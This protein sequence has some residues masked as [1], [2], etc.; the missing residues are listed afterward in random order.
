MPRACQEVS[1][2]RIVV[3]VVVC[4]LFGWQ[5]AFVE[6]NLL[7][8][9]GFE[10]GEAFAE[11]WAIEMWAEDEGVSDILLVQEG[12]GDT[13]CLRIENNAPNDARAVQHVNVEPARIYKL[14]GY[15]KAENIPEDTGGAMLSVMD[16]Y[17]IYPSVYDTQGEW[18]HREC[19]VRTHAQQETMA[20]AARLGF[21]GGD[22]EGKAWFDD[23]RLEMIRMLPAGAQLIV[24]EDPL[25]YG[26][27][28]LF[29]QEQEK[30]VPT[31]WIAWLVLLAILLVYGV[32]RKGM[33]HKANKDRIILR[34][35]SSCSF[36]RA[37]YL[38]MTL[39]T[40]FTAGVCFIGLGATRAPQTYWKST[41]AEEQ[42][43]F[44]LGDTVL[45][46]MLY[47]G[48]VHAWDHMFSVEVSENGKDWTP[49]YMASM[50]EGDCFAWQ[51]LA[52]RKASAEGEPLWDSMPLLCKGR[53]VKLR[54]DA[55]NLML[56][57]I[58]FRT[59][60][61]ESISPMLVE[62]HT[63][64]AGGLEGAKALFDEPHTVPETPGHFNS[65]YFDEVYYVRT[66]YE[67]ANGLEPY[68]WTHPPLGKLLIALG[69]E[70][71]GITPFGWRFMGALAGTLMVPALYFCAKMIFSKRH[72]AFAAAS[73]LALDM[74]HLVQSRIAT[75]DSLAVLWIIIMYACVLC[76]IQLD[77]IRRR[78]KGIPLLFASGAAMGIACAIKW[79]GV[80][81]AVGMALL[82][83]RSAR[84]TLRRSARVFWKAAFLCVLCFAALPF[85]VY[86]VSYMPHFASEGGLSP[87]RF[88][89]AQQSMLHYHAGLA[90]THPFMS[91]WYDW[92]LMLR[93]MWYYHGLYAAKGNVSTII[94]MGN[95]AIWWV[96]CGAVIYCIY[97]WAVQ[98]FRKKEPQDDRPAMLLLCLAAQLLPWMWIT[99]PTFIYHYF[100]SI[101]F[102][103][104]CTVYMFE[105][106][107]GEKKG[108]RWAL[109]VY[110]TVTCMLFAGYYPLCTGMEISRTWA[111]AMNWL[112]AL[113]WK[114]ANEGFWLLY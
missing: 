108:R 37:D 86:Y 41:Q 13:R 105:R 30:S 51:Y 25:E 112:R 82:L 27:A 34:Q 33:A 44:D 5:E 32:R 57:E 94:S 20:V 3:C 53:Y 52:P 65:T 69:M 50:A 1:M 45:F 46:Q 36:V 16:S 93:P 19:Y 29:E 54:P 101:P 104:L 64:T 9:G 28:A 55:E 100:A 48:G 62:E 106:I 42:V 84:D 35:T 107:E 4:L 76:Y 67:Y 40:A 71:F 70:I 102:L 18:V 43:V 66:A 89:H 114:H 77:P 10:Q 81:A 78:T 59:P 14:S 58:A 15:I 2:R 92:P 87:E 38:V 103:I 6:Q 8:N 63:Q 7:Q 79:T 80:Y 21:Y 99:R 23:L 113:D 109:P 96:G 85:L 90:Q 56:M 49:P 47:Y 11:H 98:P 73:L 75:L 111:D 110:L 24:L 91:A 17:A 22:A 97:A 88:W 61:G 72:Y 68:E 95:P 12:R 60:T 26:Y 39:L 74:M 83:G 31:Q